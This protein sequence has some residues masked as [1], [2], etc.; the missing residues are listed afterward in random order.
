MTNVIADVL[1]NNTD[2]PV[3]QGDSAIAGHAWQTE[4][5]NRD[6]DDGDADEYDAAIT[7]PPGW[8]DIGYMDENETQ[9]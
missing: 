9:P 8:V 2:P 1:I 4:A 6:R 5:W 3:V 7:S